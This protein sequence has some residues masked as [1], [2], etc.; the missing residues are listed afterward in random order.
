MAYQTDRPPALNA[1]IPQ[2]I[3]NPE[4]DDSKYGKQTG[5]TM[6][7]LVWLGTEKVALDIVPKPKIIGDRD[8]IVAVT[9]TTICGSD[10]HLYHNT[11]PGLEKGDILGH[12][13][14]GVIDE[15][16]PGVQGLK[17]G[18]RVVASFQIACGDCEFCNKGLSSQCAKTNANPTMKSLYGSTTGA[19]F[20]YSHITGG[21]AGGQ[22]EYVRVPYGDVNLL[23]LPADVPDEKAL[24]LSDVLCT[25]WH[26]VVDTGVHKGDVVAIWGAGPIGQMAADFSF[27][28][29]AS[30]VILI[31][32]KNGAWR[33]DYVKEKLPK[34]ETLDYSS[35]PRGETVPQALWRT[36]PNGI[37]VA[38]EC[39]AGEYEKSW[40]HWAE[41]RVGAENDSSDILN[42]MIES[43]KS[44][45]RIGVSGVYVGY[46]SARPFPSRLSLAQHQRLMNI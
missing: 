16:G 3:S 30:R 18:Q 5:E 20:G 40:I 42:E 27:Y 2:D 38:L 7:A 34:V 15:L 35:L 17:K 10:L 4:K 37:D 11:V 21:F 8:V 24:F 39:A 28:H 25:A 23:P 6:K 9:G 43:V 1:T 46:V 26:A 33:L 41:R 29:G 31:D 45:G 44:F 12:E 19:F 14:C 32:G 22:A 13:F 36:V